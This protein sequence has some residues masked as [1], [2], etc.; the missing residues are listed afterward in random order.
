[1]RVK[2]PALVF[3]PLCCLDFPSIHETIVFRHPNTNRTHW[4]I[5]TLGY[6]E[7]TLHSENLILWIYIILLYESDLLQQVDTSKNV[8]VKCLLL[9]IRSHMCVFPHYLTFV[10]SKVFSPMHWQCLLLLKMSFKWEIV[11]C[12]GFI[13]KTRRM[14]VAARSSQCRAVA[15][16]FQIH[17]GHYL[18]GVANQIPWDI[19]TS[20]WSI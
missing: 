3:G 2:R 18:L 1:M 8:V 15:F 11:E 12:V 7:W 16:V 10:G 19:S 5:V 20:G 6:S 4:K 13:R 17:S 9:S 14:H